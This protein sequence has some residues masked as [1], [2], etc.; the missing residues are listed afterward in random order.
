[1]ATPERMAFRS[2]SSNLYVVLSEL[3]TTLWTRDDVLESKLKGGEGGM[4]RYLT[5]RDAAASLAEAGSD[6][7]KMPSNAV[8]RVAD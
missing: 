1:M 3:V 4:E 2:L 8:R 5:R 6:R 7:L